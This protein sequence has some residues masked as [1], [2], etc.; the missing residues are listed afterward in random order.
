MH[1]VGF[2]VRI[3]HDARSPERQI[4]VVHTTPLNS[5]QTKF[6]VTDLIPPSLRPLLTSLSHTSMYE[7]QPP[8]W[9]RQSQP[10]SIVKPWS[11]K[12]P[13]PQNTLSPLYQKNT[14]EET[15]TINKTSKGGISVTFDVKVRKILCSPRILLN[16]KTAFIL[17]F[18]KSNASA[19]RN[20]CLSTIW[21]RNY[22]VY[23]LRSM[24]LL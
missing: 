23:S 3:Y 11:Y 17:K 18:C 12:S 19:I 24:N 16:L 14:S 2:I 20:C 21:C 9:L 10:E 13:R 15:W 6:S 22:T 8:R 4:P 5:L 1:L 7:P